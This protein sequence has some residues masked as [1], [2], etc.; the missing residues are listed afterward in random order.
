MGDFM[1]FDSHWE[2]EDRLGFIRKVY[3]ILGSQLLFT[4]CFCLLPFYNLNTQIWFASQQGLAI[5]LLIVALIL[6]CAMI[7]VKSLSRTVPTNYILLFV[8]T[9]CET[10]VVAHI[11]AYYSPEIVI[12][13][14]FMTAA[15]VV[16]LT[17][18]ALT[19]KTDF[20]ILGGVGFSL[21]ASLVVFLIFTILWGF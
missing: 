1:K 11:C 10:F 14:M 15:I 8:F 7:C 18:Y 9:F 6:A 21:I 19:T 16:G 4:A 2:C 3:G 12:A 5:G 13:A 17:I 20:H